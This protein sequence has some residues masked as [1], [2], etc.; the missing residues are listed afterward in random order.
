MLI[1][2]FDSPYDGKP[3]VAILTGTEVPS[4]N[5]K[6][7]KMSQLWYLRA[8]IPPSVA[9]RTGADYSVCKGCD[10]RPATYDTHR[11]YVK[12]W[13]GPASVWQ[14]WQRGV[15]KW[16]PSH[17][18]WGRHTVR[19][20]AYGNPSVYRLDKTREITR[21]VK[22][23]TMYIHDWM[24]ADLDWADIAMASVS[25][26][27]Q[28]RLANRMGYR[29]FR[30]KNWWDPVLP[31]EVV[32]PAS[33][34]MGHKTTCERCKLCKGNAINAKNIV[35]DDH[36]PTKKKKRVELQLLGENHV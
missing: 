19:F 28:K 27:E 24:S 35:L 23:W 14:A 13:E 34:E 8:D 1:D 7:G 15:Y 25:S 20:G 36:G 10:L 12:T 26:E 5:P 30:L 11:C 21:K 17:F 31:D 22:N 33:K 3:V 9:T 32:C 29:T 6:T 4:D 18:D 16:I 2:L